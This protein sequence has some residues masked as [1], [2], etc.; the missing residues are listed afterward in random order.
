MTNLIRDIRS[1]SCISPFNSGF[2]EKS[3]EETN[4]A[5]LLKIATE[6]MEKY[7]PNSVIPEEELYASLGIDK[8]ALDAIGEIELE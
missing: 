5:R 6:R 8:K 1:K 3:I 4:D 7:D 2:A